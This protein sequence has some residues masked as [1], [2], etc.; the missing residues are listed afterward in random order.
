MREFERQQQQ[1]K[2]SFLNQFKFH[3]K[4]V[5]TNKE[6]VC[7]LQNKSL[8]VIKMIHIQVSDADCISPSAPNLRQRTF[9]TLDGVRAALLQRRKNRSQMELGQQQ[10]DAPVE[11]LNQ[12]TRH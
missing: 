1:V 10:R 5:L 6:K 12:P 4:Q 11:R 8:E 7:V 9:G 3:S 2:S